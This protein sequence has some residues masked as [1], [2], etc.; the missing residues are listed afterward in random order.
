MDKWLKIIMI[1]IWS[2]IAIL[3][4]AFLIF[5]I[6]KSEGSGIIF[7]DFKWSDVGTHLQKQQDVSL[8][9]KDK[10]IMNF[11]SENVQI[12]STDEDKLRIIEKSSGRLDENEKFIVS[13]ENNAVVI[14]QVKP[15][16]SFNI[17]GLGHFNREI[18]LFIPKSYNKDLQVELSSANIVVNDDLKLMKFTSKQT[19]GNFQC[20]GNLM[21]DEIAI[22][23]SSGNIKGDK[24]SSK[25]YKINVT[26]GNIKIN[27]LSGSG[28]AATSSGDI[29]I[30]YQE[31]LDHSN[32]SSTSGNVNLT[33]P[34]EK[35]FEF[36]GKCSSGNIDSNFNLSYSSKSKNQAA[37]RIGNGP[38]KTINVNTTSGNIHILQK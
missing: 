11:S 26:S 15:S 29:V 24:I 31:I 34:K 4:T 33:I 19:S 20:N 27:S 25:S 30:G 28:D 35:N 12:W 21:A 17:F 16:I 13:N 18:E 32:I 22:K 14:K 2:F 23:T 36:K 3:L 5:N 6:K 1:I 37:A 7:N 38:Y 8:E 10:I 9:N